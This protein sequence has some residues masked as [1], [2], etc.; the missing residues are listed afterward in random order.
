MNIKPIYNSV[1]QVNTA[2]R[3]YAK[4][5]GIEV[6]RGK[7]QNDQVTDTRLAYCDFID[8][9]HRSELISDYLHQNA[10]YF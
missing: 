9:L 1:K 5:Q 3:L 8:D 6:R 4:Q 7:P 10:H 2:F